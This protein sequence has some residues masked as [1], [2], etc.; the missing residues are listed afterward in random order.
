MK[1]PLATLGLGCALLSVVPTSAQL[2]TR[3][4]TYGHLPLRKAILFDSVNVQGA[5]Y[6]LVQQIKQPFSLL[7]RKSSPIQATARGFFPSTVSK[8]MTDGQ[9]DVY[10]I[11]VVAPSYTKGTLTLKGTGRYAL[12]WG[13]YLMGSNE[14]QPAPSDS[15]PALSVPFSLEASHATLQVRALRLPADSMSS[16]F[17]LSFTPDPG[18]PQ[19]DSMATVSGKRYIDWDYI[20]NGK[21]LYYSSVSPSGKY[22]L[23]TYSD[24]T[25]KAGA[26][27]QE[28]RDASG[29][30]L[31][32]TQ[33]L[34]GAQWMPRQ[35]VLIIQRSNGLRQQLLK[36]NPINGET[37]VW[38]DNLP[39]T[40][41]TISPDERT[42]YCYQE[43]K[44]PEKNP[45]AIRRL[46][47]NDR[48]PSWRNR[49]AIYRYDIATGSYEPLV[50][51]LSSSGIQD[52]SQDGKRLLL[53]KHTTD[54]TRTPYDL[55]SLYIYH[56]ESGKI[57]TL[58]R[59][60]FEIAQASFI[61]HTQDLLITAS[62]NAFNGIANT[63]PNKATAN[64]YEHELFRYNIANGAVLPLTKDFNP[65]VAE[66]EYSD[67][68]QAY[69]FS[70]EDGSRKALY[71]LDVKTNK[72]SPIAQQE[73]VVRHFSV[74]SQGTDL[75]YIGQSL[76]NADRL[77][78][79]S[80]SGKS[81]L[82]WDL[83]K[84]KLQDIK[85]TPAQNFVYTAPDGTKIDGWYYLPPNFDPNKKYPMIVYYYGGTSPL[86]R[87]LET[88]Y[89]LAMFASQGY[90][91]YSLNPRGCT[92]YGQAFAADHLNAWGTKTA[93]DIIGAVKAFTAQHSF[94][95]AKKIGCCG[96]SYGGFMTQYLQTKTDIFAAA[97]SHAGISSISSY[98]AGGY[99]GIGY[100]AVASAGSYPWN[101]PDLYTKHSPLF[102]ADKIHTPL[103]LI[104]GTSDVNVPPSESTALYNALKI[105]GRKVEL[106]EITGEDHHIVEPDRQ[107][108]WMRTMCAWF[109]KYLQDAPQWWDSMY[110]ATPYDQ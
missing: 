37:S 1:R 84:E 22:V 48:M 110:P 38:V 52:I 83:S 68:L 69:I 59:D 95:D 81:S 47:P 87:Q 88:V 29:K 67:K 36:V 54:F 4:K 20:T 86:S 25:P 79:V 90:I 35:D 100:S 30:I 10:S 91:A 14:Q 109:A 53:S 99:W 93:D 32:T 94:V 106:I 75:W 39:N 15:V 104:H 92:G 5:P 19:L 13:D 9:I 98:W 102:N 108:I 96:A 58:L 49:S 12:Y 8:G 76:N 45:M 55:T 85:L 65:N 51:G 18:L 72:I 82:V 46:S 89:D 21:R 73:D 62:P 6:D 44:G 64:G 66:V 101:N 31:R 103:L 78:K 16:D 56:T 97:I 80:A 61:P 60:Q 26:T 2:L 40:S 63:L 57:D 27:Y 42:L 70:T 50:Y 41:Y 33:G 24:K 43:E 71:K 77:Y 23:I 3:G 74:A 28:V 105:L 17:S 107:N 7:G 34:S 11:D